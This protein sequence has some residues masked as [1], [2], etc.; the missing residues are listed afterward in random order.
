MA[1]T[2]LV[3]CVCACAAQAGGDLCAFNGAWAFHKNGSI[4]SAMDGK[5][6]QISTKDDITVSV[7]VSVVKCGCTTYQPHGAK[8][9][10]G[11]YWTIYFLGGHRQRTS[12]SFYPPTWTKMAKYLRCYELRPYLND[13][14]FLG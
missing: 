7:G 13:I 11:T 8:P 6:L 9:Q 5:C 12:S 14:I 4:T 10:F 2:I 1:P 3:V